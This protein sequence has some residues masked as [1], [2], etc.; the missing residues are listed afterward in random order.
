M[1]TLLQDLRYSVRTLIER[2]GF[3]VVAALSIALGVGGVAGPER[4]PDRRRR[5]RAGRGGLRQRPL[6]PVARR[7][8]GP[9]PHLHPRRDRAGHRAAGGRARTRPVA[10]T[11]R[12]GPGDPRPQPRA[13]RPEP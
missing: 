5:A 6:L 9:R 7:A 8:A 2:P 13:Q 12:I 1:D 4:E 10:A 11:L 3:A